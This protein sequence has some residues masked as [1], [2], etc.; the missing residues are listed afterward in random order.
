MKIIKE[1]VIIKENNECVFCGAEYEFDN[2]DISVEHNEIYN[3]LPFRLC[4]ARTY[5]NHFVICPI[6]KTQN[7]LCFEKEVNRR[8]EEQ[9]MQRILQEE[10]EKIRIQEELEKSKKQVAE[11]TKTIKKKRWW[12]KN[13]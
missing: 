2:T 9:K 7:Y 6:C 3:C 8:K 12:N 11:Q 13:V 10:Q 4:D 1:P 5:T